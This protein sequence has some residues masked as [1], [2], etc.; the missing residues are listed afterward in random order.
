MPSSVCDSLRPHDLCQQAFVLLVFFSDTH[1][2]M[3]SHTAERRGPSKVCYRCYPRPNSLHSLMQTLSP[4]LIFRGSKSAQFGLNIRRQSPLKRS[5][6]E[7]EQYN[8]HFKHPPSAFL[9]LAFLVTQTLSQPLPYFICAK[10]VRNLAQIWN[11]GDLV[12]KARKLSKI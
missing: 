12:P 7:T 2:L 3:I 11:W 10:Q 4:S 9:W 1:T 5:G 8:E 6:F